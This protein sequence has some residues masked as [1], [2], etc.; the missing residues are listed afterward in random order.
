MSP[1]RAAQRGGRGFRH[2][3]M[4]KE[5]TLNANRNHRRGFTLVEVLLVLLIVGMLAAGAIVMLGGTRDRAKK[6][7]TKVLLSNL[8]TA[9]D[10]FESHMGRY[11]TEEEGL[12]ALRTKPTFENEEE[13]EN[14]AGPYIKRE[15]KDPWG[16]KINYEPVE[17]G[18]DEATA[19]LGYKIWSNGPNRTS[20]D[21]DDIR[22]W[23]E[24][25]D[26]T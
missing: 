23:D 16:Q 10:A 5:L 14:W 9:L 2:E 20:G 4:R 7:S 8:E 25:A 3:R 15:P 18:G 26:S 6:D 11:P 17:A 19:G 22:N 1:A 24:D 21:D 12:G 13:G